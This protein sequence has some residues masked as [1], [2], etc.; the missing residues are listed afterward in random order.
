M[1]VPSPSAMLT[2]LLVA[3]PVAT[4]MKPSLLKSATT[5]GLASRPIGSGGVST[6]PEQAAAVGR[7][8]QHAK[9]SR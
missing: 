4:S 7:I 9:V 1:P 6:G 2:V 8:E 5:L 3:L